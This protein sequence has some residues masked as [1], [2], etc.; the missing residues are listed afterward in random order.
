MEWGCLSDKGL[1]LQ[2]ISC[3][4]H[5]RWEEALLRTSV[6]HIIMTRQKYLGAYWLERFCDESLS[7]VDYIWLFAVEEKRKKKEDI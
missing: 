6:L 5:L 1:W 4:V 3:L 2:G 7:P